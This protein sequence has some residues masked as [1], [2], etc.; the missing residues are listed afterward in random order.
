MRICHGTSS[1]HLE[2]ILRE[3]LKPRGTKASNWKA[4]SH[5]DLVYLSQAYALHYAGNAVDKEGGNIVL[6]EIDT[7]LLPDY[8][9]NGQT[10][11]QKPTNGRTPTSR[12]NRIP[13]LLAVR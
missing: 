2:S 4:A 10:A 8:R 12:G 9:L 11:C 13:A 5:A 3:G 1:I 6:V 7:D